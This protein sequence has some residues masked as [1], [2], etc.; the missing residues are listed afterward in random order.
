MSIL[1]AQPPSRI[2]RIDPAN[3]QFR[4]SQELVTGS[5]DSRSLNIDSVTPLD[6]FSQTIELDGLQ[7]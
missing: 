3:L 1:H 5:L 4:L 2:A 7:A 6:T